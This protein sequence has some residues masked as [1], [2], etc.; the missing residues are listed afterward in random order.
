MC[1]FFDGEAPLRFAAMAQAGSETTH[2]IQI[3]ISQSYVSVNINVL[4]W[5]NLNGGSNCASGENCS[6]S[7]IRHFV[8]NSVQ[9]NSCAPRCR[10][11]YRMLVVG[12]CIL[13]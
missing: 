8:P 13:Q 12:K 10:N 3:L 1:F 6:D 11:H 4:L 2:Y 5:L 7:G 9:M